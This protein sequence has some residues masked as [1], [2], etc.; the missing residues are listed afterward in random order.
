MVTLGEKLR[1]FAPGDPI[2]HRSKD[3]EQNE[4]CEISTYLMQRDHLQ[5]HQQSE[6]HYG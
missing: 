2:Y 4:T 3:E 1:G 5:D 6:E